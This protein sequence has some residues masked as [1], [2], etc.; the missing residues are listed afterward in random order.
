MPRF[1]RTRARLALL[2]IS[3]PIGAAHAGGAHTVEIDFATHDDYDLFGKLTMPDSDGAHAVVIYVQTAEGMTVDMKRP[4]GRA[5]TFNYFDLYA[6][7]LPEMNWAFFRYEG[8]GI[9]IGDAP[10]RYEQIDREVYDTSTLENKVRDV[11]SAVQVVKQQAGVD[12]SRIFLM[13]ASEGTLLAAQAAA[14][15][16]GEIAGLV[17][18]GVM[19]GNMRDT[20]RYILTD[21]ADL[22]YRRLF[23]TDRDGKISKPEFEA[24][25]AHYRATVLRGISFDLL[26]VDHDGVLTA[27]DTRARAKSLL[28]AI[29]SESYAILDAWAQNAAGVSTPKGWFKDHFAQPP[30]WDSLARLDIPVGFFQGARDT[31][32]PIDGVRKLEALAKQAGKLKM[33]FHYFADLDH[34]LGI[35]SYFVTDVLPEGHKAIFEFIKRH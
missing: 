32:V 13:G 11:L 16:P 8:R 30:I 25:P 12:A 7:L 6:K 5:G 21:G 1:S 9:R 23:D 22:T 26:D 19:S 17:L 15:A 35:G 34:S 2:L 14:R 29:D 10:P 33:E 27:A 24:D 31:S 18:Y 20:F 3:M 28:D 4:G